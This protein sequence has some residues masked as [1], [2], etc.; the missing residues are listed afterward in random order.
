MNVPALAYAGDN[1]GLYADFWKMYLT[2]R[3]NENTKTMKARVRLD[4]LKVGADLLRRFFWYRGSLW[5]L[6]SI[7]NYSL[8]T[9]DPAECE[10]VQ[11]RD[12]DAYL[13]G[14]Y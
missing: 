5:V 11:V 3:F 9:F 7:S 6:A 8:T 13:N 12:K 4:G 1:V 10:F 14:Q 2:D